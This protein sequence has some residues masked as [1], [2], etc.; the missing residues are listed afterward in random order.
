MVAQYDARSPARRRAAQSAL[1]SR[2]V[3]ARHAYERAGDTPRART[4]R[5]KR[6]TVII[7]SVMEF[8]HALR[9]ARLRAPQRCGG[10]A[11]SFFIINDAARAPRALNVRTA[12]PC[13]PQRASGI[14][15]ARPL[16]N[17]WTRH[18]T[19]DPRRARALGVRR[20]YAKRAS[21]E[22]HVYWQYS[23][24]GSA[25]PGPPIGPPAVVVREEKERRFVYE[26][27]QQPL[28]L[29]ACKHRSAVWR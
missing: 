29:R 12:F 23:F 19:R 14:L 25:G 10:A 1:W 16:C 13:H 6:N 8:C 5:T 2:L 4:R 26:T 15:C 20:S 28:T 17:G 21:G 18:L 11:G 27:S 24:G 7:L 22:G 3:A 9:A